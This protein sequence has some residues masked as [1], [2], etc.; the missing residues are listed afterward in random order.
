MGYEQPRAYKGRLRLT[1][2]RR[3]EVVKEYEGSGLAQAEFAR[4]AGLSATTFAHWV[5]LRGGMRKRRPS[6][7]R[8][9]R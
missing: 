6:R 8:R 3:A 2:E 1:R 5:Q 4:R 9:W 7:R